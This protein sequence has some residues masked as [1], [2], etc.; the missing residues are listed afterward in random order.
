MAESDKPVTKV[1]D[2]P[3]QGDKVPDEKASESVQDGGRA[4]IPKAVFVEDVDKFMQE[5]ENSSAEQ[6]L[7]RLDEQH[8]K[9]KFL[10]YN[11]QEKKRR[12][13][14]RIPDIQKTLNMIKFLK[15]PQG[16]KS[17]LTH[18]QMSAGVYATAAVPPTDTVYLWLGVSYL[19][20]Y[21]LQNSFI[22]FNN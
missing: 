2:P 15:S 3:S 17:F 12:L 14:S 22:L 13:R 20:V 8:T 16:S 18:Y 1:A 5:P 19:I 4:N 9:Y 6:V 11:L 21:T 7:R 10:E